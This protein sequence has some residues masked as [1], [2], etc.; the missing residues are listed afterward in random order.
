MQPNAH[1]AQQRP[2]YHPRLHM[3]PITVPTADPIRSTKAEVSPPATRVDLG[4]TAA[5][6]ARSTKAEV[7]P[8]A[9]RDRGLG[10]RGRLGTL[11]KG[12]GITPG[13]TSG[14]RKGFQDTLKR[15]TKA[16]VSPPATPTSPRLHRIDFPPLN[17]GRGI[18]PG[19]TP[20]CT[21]WGKMKKIFCL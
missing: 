6:S 14:R 10:S 21:I 13:Y 11:N 7:S 18:T 12:R 3:P 15:S 8:P 17:K 20:K 16:E 19:Y 9:T 2:R 4:S 1:F 5:M